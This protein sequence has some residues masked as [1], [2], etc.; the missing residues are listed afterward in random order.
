[1]TQKSIYMDTLLE[2]SRYVDTLRLINMP[3]CPFSL[4]PCRWTNDPTQWPETPVLPRLPCGC[5]N[6]E[7]VYKMGYRKHGIRM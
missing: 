3:A 6:A 7:E 2:P 4:P 5:H 1:M